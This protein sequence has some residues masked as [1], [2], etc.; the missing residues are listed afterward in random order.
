M[1]CSEGTTNFVCL[2]KNQKIK[3]KKKKNHQDFDRYVWS[4][5]TNKFHVL[6]GIANDFILKLEQV[7]RA[8][9]LPFLSYLGEAGCEKMTG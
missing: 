4:W 7:I 6:M 1:F 9:L 8:K 3:K 5:S 2:A